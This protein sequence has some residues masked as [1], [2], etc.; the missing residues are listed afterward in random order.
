MDSDMT[1]DEELKILRADWA[2]L[3][4]QVTGAE[5]RRAGDLR[6]GETFTNS[7]GEAMLTDQQLQRLRNQA[8]ECEQAAD[9]IEAL[10]DEGEALHAILREAQA[11]MDVL[12]GA[13]HQI[14][15][16]SRNSMSSRAECGRIARAALAKEPK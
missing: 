1:P 6:R 2:A 11:E 4:A 16:A 7:G 3:V 9:E 8:N 12:R 14:S 10:R 5:S 15:L 13:L